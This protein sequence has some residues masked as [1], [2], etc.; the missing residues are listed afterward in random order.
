VPARNKSISVLYIDDDPSLLEIGKAFLELSGQF[1]VATTERPLS[2]MA[3]L[4]KEEYDCIISDY[5]MPVLDGIGLL[6][7]I[8]VRYPELPFILFTGKGREDVVIQAF[9][10]G[11]DYYVQ[12]GRDVQSQFRELSHK[13]RLAV[14]KR[15]ADRAL[16]ESEERYR[17]VV[18]DEN[19]YICR[20]RPDG[21]YIFANNAFCRAFGVG[22]DAIVN[23]RFTPLMPAEDA[24]AI[25]DHLASLTKAQPQG[26][27]EHRIHHP[28]GSVRWHQWSDRALFS[29]SGILVE[30]Q[31]IGRD[32]T[33]QKTAE[34]NLLKTHD[35]L[36]SAFEQLT[37]TE[38]ELRTSYEDLASSQHRLEERETILDAV[39]QASPIPQF[40]IDKDHHVLY[41]NQALA[42]YSGIAAHEVVGTDQHWRAF[43]QNKRPCLADLLVDNAMDRL[44]EWYLD[45]FEKSHLIEGAYSAT[46]FFPHMGWEGK[47]LYFTAGLI[48]DRNGAIIG[49]VETL[50]DVTERRKKEEELAREHRELTASYEQ[51]AA[52]EEELR[53]NYE[54]L[55]H[56]EEELRESR[57]LYR[58]VVEDQTDLICRFRPDGTYVFVNDAYCRYFNKQ[59]EEILGRVFRPEVFVDERE[60]V[61]DIF[62]RLTPEQ[63][64][65]SGNQR[66]IFPDGSLRW[67]NW[68]DRAIFDANGTLIEYQS[69]GRDITDVMT[70]E[71]KLQKKN[72]MLH[73]AYGQLAAAE[74]ELRASFEDLARSRQRIKESEERYRAVVEGQT[75][76]ICRFRPDGTHVFVNE[77]Y[78]RYLKKSREEILGSVVMPEIPREE[79]ERLARHFRGLTPERP[80]GRIDHQIILPGGAVTWQSWVDHAIFD[81]NGHLVEYQSVGRDISDYQRAVRELCES[82]KKYRDQEAAPQNGNGHQ[83]GFSPGG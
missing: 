81:E 53:N 21:T 7:Q 32:I 22:E 49:A 9:D 16:R 36:R 20:F 15:Y 30:F 76:L 10:A 38:E 47:W 42:A 4:E 46:D 45:R 34:L 54:E 19:E 14:E 71:I 48:H 8:R 41:W 82:E 60:Q 31:S 70:A 18:Q 26:T 52:T 78:C 58:A 43:Y 69:V 11:A 72:E 65:A 27:I 2:V 35:E 63:P 13:I 59:R 62:R 28:D 5:Q 50:E 1:T 25:R 67:Q 3:L 40:V 51:L 68:V 23:R 74:E 12:K 77:A 64:V 57:K 44:P 73:A 55:S 17:N 83:P 24:R 66:T 33:D 61:R 56:L 29:E 79:R 80:V 39:I 75:E 37:A 6:K